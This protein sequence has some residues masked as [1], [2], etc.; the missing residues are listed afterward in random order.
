M[1]ESLWL[2][3]LLAAIVIVFAALVNELGVWLGSSTPGEEHPWAE[4]PSSHALAPL[5]PVEPLDGWGCSSPSAATQPRKEGDDAT[6]SHGGGAHPYDWEAD[7]AL[8]AAPVVVQ[9][10]QARR[11]A[12]D[13]R[14]SYRP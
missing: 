11:E 4:P 6:R 13:R 7:R 3:G 1:I 9:P 14:G 8:D 12:Q 10:S 5:P 2:V